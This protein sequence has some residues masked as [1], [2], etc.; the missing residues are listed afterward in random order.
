MLKL[1]IERLISD[2]LERVIVNNKVEIDKYKHTQ[3]IVHLQSIGNLMFRNSANLWC[4]YFPFICTLLYVFSV[5][6]LDWICAPVFT[7]NWLHV[8]LFIP[9]ISVTIVFIVLI[10]PQTFAKF[11]VW[12]PVFNCLSCFFFYLDWIA[13][14]PILREVEFVPVSCC[15]CSFLSWIDCIRLCLFSFFYLG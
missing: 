15:L 2:H 8:F 13:Y 10:W 6:S 4:I 12:V 5:L 11:I 7:Y 14:V 1:R 9:V 3:R